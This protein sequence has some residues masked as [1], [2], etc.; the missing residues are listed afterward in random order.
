M[1]NTPVFNARSISNSSFDKMY[2][3]Y[4]AGDQ[5]FFIRIGGQG[6]LRPGLTHQLGILGLL[7]EPMIKKRAEKKEKELIE[8]I[9]QT[10]PEQLL[11]RHK[12]NFRL[13]TVDLQEGT[14]DPPSFFATHGLHVGRWQ[15]NLRD[16]KKMTF[17]FEN[18]EDMRIA[19]DV[20]PKLF[21]STFHVNARWN[22]TKKKYE[23]REDAA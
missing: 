15:M 14:L 18:A 21:S 12:D 22:E 17:Q 11:A 2:R 23:K 1:G 8:T 9:D 13:R 3:I 6:G 5:L 7:I 10:D 20:L 4:A 16:G 19:M